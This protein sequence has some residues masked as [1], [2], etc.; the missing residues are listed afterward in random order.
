[1]N[2]VET[3]LNIQAQVSSIQ[4]ARELLDDLETL[5]AKYE[6]AA[7]ISIFPQEDFEELYKLPE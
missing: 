5:G 6:I 7:T 2:G 3:T 4:K 1:M